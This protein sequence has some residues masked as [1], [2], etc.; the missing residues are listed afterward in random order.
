MLNLNARCPLKLEKGIRG[1]LVVADEGFLGRGDI[2][3]I[4]KKLDI[5]FIEGD[6]SISVTNDGRPLALALTIP[7]RL[8]K[9]MKRVKF[10]LGIVQMHVLEG[11]F[12]EPLQ[13]HIALLSRVLPG[14]FHLEDCLVGKARAEFLTKASCNIAQDRN[15]PLSQLLPG[16]GN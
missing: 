3:I 5:L 14:E 13:A 1:V 12:D 15:L 9:V 8:L 11:I 7:E 10:L 4:L 2:A 16:V 6:G